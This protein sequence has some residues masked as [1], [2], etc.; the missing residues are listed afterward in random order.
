M[1]RSKSNPVLYLLLSHL[2]GAILISCGIPDEFPPVAQPPPQSP[3]IYVVNESTFY[4]YDTVHLAIDHP[5]DSNIKF[6]WEQLIKVGD[7][8]IVSKSPEAKFIAYQP[9]EFVISAKS[10]LGLLK[11]QP[12]NFTI[13][14]KEKTDPQIP[15]AIIRIAQPKVV[16]GTPILLSASESFDPQNEPLSYSWKSLNGGEFLDTGSENTTF[17][18]SE[19][20]KYIVTLQVTDA[21]LNK[22][23]L[24]IDSV[25]INAGLPPIINLKS[26]KSNLTVSEILTLDASESSDPDN[27]SVKFEWRSIVEDGV[28]TNS[29]ATATFKS[30][31]AGHYVIYLKVTDEFGYSTQEFINLT[32]GTPPPQKVPQACLNNTTFIAEPNQLVPLDASCSS[33]PQNLTLSYNWQLLNGGEL[34]DINNTQAKFHSG[35]SG[36]YLVSLVVDNGIHSSIPVLATITVNADERPTAD[37]GPDKVLRCCAEIFLDGSQSLDP[38]GAELAYLWE[39]LNGG[40]IIS[41]TDQSPSFNVSVPGTYSILLKVSDGTNESAPDIVNI[42]YQANQRPIASAGLDLTTTIG[43]PVS[44][45]A[46]NSSDADGDPLKYEWEVLNGGVITNSDQ[47]VATFSANE[48]MTYSIALT[49]SDT[50]DDS[51]IDIVN[52]VVTDPDPSDPLPGSIPLADA[53]ADNSYLLFE[54]N[55]VQLDGSASSDPS[56]K[57]L[58]FSWLGAETNPTPFNDYTSSKITPELNLTQPGQYAFILTVFNGTQYSLPD[59]VLITV[60]NPDLFVSKTDPSD[61][62]HFNTITEALEVAQPGYL[63]FVKPGIYN[64]NVDNFIS[65]VTL[66]STNLPETII[67]G[68]NTASTITLNNVNIAT[69]RGFTIKNGGDNLNTGGITCINSTSS[70]NIIDNLIEGN[71]D[72]IRLIDANDIVVEGCQI[73]A[74]VYNGI[75]TNNSS[76]NVF[77]CVIESNGKDIPDDPV[78]PAGITVENSSAGTNN[79]L[80]ININQNIFLDNENNHI[81]L[82]NNSRVVVRGN[83]F[84]GI[85]GGII[86]TEFSKAV[87]TID[88]NR[89]EGTTGSPIFCIDSEVDILSNW[90]YSLNTTMVSGINLVSCSGIVRENTIDAYPIGIEVSAGYPP[91]PTIENTNIFTNNGQDLDYSNTKC[92]DPN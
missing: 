24:T 28:I 69:I 21:S 57:T 31:I 41:S 22:S 71:I 67:D 82:T 65:N 37:A 61:A 50:W 8:L 2:F 5:S 87:M 19:K 46:S 74:N 66:L 53:G 40:I 86:A 68:G 39:P 62:T 25:T 43:E 56:G 30:D 32:V 33:D 10:C 59:Q 1:N 9:G 11:S 45:D 4:P 78:G 84:Q 27:H 92:S 13:T 35:I 73:K 75:R 64:E 3:N 16:L 38:E 54:A 18:A 42:T 52:V 91:C 14:V 63:I 79:A 12:T 34:T 90:L 81:K 60:E 44:L 6:E 51:Y 76:F 88:N 70:I 23:L 58:T 83:T 47:Q 36:T 7:T 48:P 80:S 17:T 49:V 55:N 85:G 26:H 20:G 89:F 29:G 72:G 77:D 15:T